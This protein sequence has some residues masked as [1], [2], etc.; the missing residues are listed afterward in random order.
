MEKVVSGVDIG[1]TNTVF[2]IVDKQGKVL[3]EDNLK[4]TDYPEVKDFVKA[5]SSGIRK[6]MSGLKEC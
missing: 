5:L 4:T 1:G 2:G 3:A 6:L